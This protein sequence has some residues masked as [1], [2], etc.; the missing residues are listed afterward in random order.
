MDNIGGND[1]FATTYGLN[2]AKYV[3][4]YLQNGQQSIDNFP[5]LVCYVRSY[6]FVET[7]AW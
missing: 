4:N 6:D 1:M 7:N 2:Y 5:V 3:T